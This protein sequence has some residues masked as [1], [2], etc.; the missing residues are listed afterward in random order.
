MALGGERVE[1]VGKARRPESVSKP[2][3]ERTPPRPNMS[4]G[5]KEANAIRQEANKQAEEL[6]TRLRRKQQKHDLKFGHAIG[7]LAPSYQNA[8]RPKIR[9]KEN[10]GTPKRRSAHSIWQGAAAA[11]AVF[12]TGAYAKEQLQSHDPVRDPIAASSTLEE[13]AERAPLRGP[14][15]APVSAEDT[16][17]AALRAETSTGVDADFL[18]ALMA[19][20]SGW[21]TE[22]NE[23][24]VN[25]GE[26]RKSVV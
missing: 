25:I 24:G 10:N 23:M 14:E 22:T 4:E 6:L 8:I 1:F 15:W 13:T 21:N 16:Y 9:P 19:Q 20:E 5:K 3:R 18:F 7:V 11:L 17:R 26:D 2:R 12:F